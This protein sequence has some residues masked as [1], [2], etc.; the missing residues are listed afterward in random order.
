VIVGRR[1]V[2]VGMTN[3]VDR[4]QRKTSLMW[5]DMTP[6]KHVPHPRAEFGRSTSNGTSVIK[7]IRPK[8]LTRRSRS[9][10]V[11]GTDTDRSGT[12]DFP[13]TFRSK[14]W[15]STISEIRRRRRRISQAQAK[16]SVPGSITHYSNNGIIITYQTSL[17]LPVPSIE[18][19]NHQ[20]S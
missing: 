19:E 13:I 11:I 12:Y 14:P 3:N 5:Y 2:V 4:H 6:R 7:E 1:P 16:A 18:L 15:A 10:K 20:I 8:S 9:L 17:R